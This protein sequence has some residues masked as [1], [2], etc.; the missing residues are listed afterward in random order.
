LLWRQA[1]QR[2]RE[3]APADILLGTVGLIVGLLVGLLASQPLRLLNPPWLSVAV[4]GL[5]MLTCAYMAVNVALWKRRDFAS[6]FPR[7][8]PAE[9]V[10]ADERTVILDTSAVIDGRFVDLHRLGFLPGALRVPR[11]VLGELQTL[12]DSAD[13]T[14]RARGR[15]GLDLLAALPDADRVQVF[16]SDYN[17]TSAVDEKLLRLA[18]DVKSALVTVD[19]NL[20]KVARVRGIEVLNL[21]DAAASLRPNYL[22]GE[23]VRLKIVKPGKE[24]GQG[25]GYLDDGTMVVVQGGRDQVGKEACVEVTSVLQSSAGRMVF[26]RVAPSDVAERESESA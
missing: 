4:T 26:A 10:T 6:M 16:E 12:A 13:D 20:A 23:V 24:L 19:Y 11:F 22:P 5:L 14:R 7:L 2:V 9:L 8:A 25:V 18:T 1:E 21:N 15:R 17:D 3:I